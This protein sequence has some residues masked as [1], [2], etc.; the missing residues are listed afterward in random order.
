[1]R[2][3][4]RI[5]LSAIAHL[6]VAPILLAA[7]KAN[8]ETLAAKAL[9][10]DPHLR[11][12]LKTPVFNQLRA[13]L[14]HGQING[15]TY[16]VADGDLRLD[17]DELLFYAKQRENQRITFASGVA[18]GVGDQ[19]LVMKVNGKIVRW[20]PGTVLKY[21][22]LRSTFSDQEFSMVVTNMN[23]A[24][25]DWESTCGVKF[26]YVP[27]ADGNPEFSVPEEVTF[28]VQKVDLPDSTIAQAF[29]PPDPRFRHQ[30]LI[31]PGYFGPGLGFD[32]VGVLRHELG[33]VIGFRHEHIRS[34]ARTLLP[35]RNGGR[36]LR[37]HQL[38]P[39]FG[40]ALLLR[41]S[42]FSTACDHP[43][44]PHG[45]A[46]GLRWTR[47]NAARGAGLERR[48][49]PQSQ[50]LIVRA[51]AHQRS[52]QRSP[53][54]LTHGGKSRRR[55]RAPVEGSTAMAIHQNSGIQTLKPEDFTGL[56]KSF[57]RLFVQ[58]Q[59]PQGTEPIWTPARENLDEQS[60]RQDAELLR[61]AIEAAAPYLP[62]DY[63]RKFVD[64]LLENLP[65]VVR[66]RDRVKEAAVLVEALA[67]AVAEHARSS[68]LRRPLQQFLAV[69]SN[70]YR[71]F[72]SPDKRSSIK[73]PLAVPQL[74]PL[75][76][77]SHFSR[78][79]PFVLPTPQTQL[80]C[81]SSVAVVNLPATYANYP[82]T[83]V[84]LAHEA[85]GHGV[86]HADPE[87][88]PD[89]AAGVRALF[90]GGPL[91]P[92]VAPNRAQA[93]GLLWSYWIDE[94]AADVYGLLNVGPAYASEPG[95]LPRSPEFRIQGDPRGAQPF[96]RRRSSNRRQLCR[97]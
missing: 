88:L 93:L 28:S 63:R 85:S 43:A 27:T 15:K 54:G 59:G 80:L 14:P 8:E 58:L 4:S 18:S 29:F 79:G 69:V 13:G 83:W 68:V 89:L 75:V 61:G 77:F 76:S 47:G 64:P 56:V 91:P 52:P 31:D 57:V 73:I 70:L 34:E 37:G 9:K 55:G 30:L 84:P 46:V 5:L 49:I 87:L 53:P 3:L 66:C 32:A 16:W 36:G 45:L 60:L 94:T 20:A 7:S 67:G 2:H 48:Q 33:H 51:V 50:S 11:N 71:S 97:W 74:P 17:E 86:L 92:G 35:G 90:G 44:R 40:D 38:R 12:A 6:A 72:L 62:L 41:R 96:R 26:Q 39:A 82:L 42:W 81:G 24:T 65:H 21:C 23:M 78:S 25:H 95:C 1:M 19:L 22:I 10:A